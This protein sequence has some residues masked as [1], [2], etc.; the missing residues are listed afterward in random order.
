MNSQYKINVAT[1][2]Q[3]YV[4]SPFV[5]PWKLLNKEIFH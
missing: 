4:T 5:R 1:V 2:V 3:G